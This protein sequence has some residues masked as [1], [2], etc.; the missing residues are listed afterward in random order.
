MAGVF[1]PRPDSLDWYAIHLPSGENSAMPLVALVWTTGNGFPSPMIGNAQMSFRVFW[2]ALLYS[3]NRPSREK[4]DATMSVPS[5][6]AALRFPR[7]PPTSRRDRC[8][9]FRFELNTMRAH[10]ATRSDCCRSPRRM[11]PGSETSPQV[12]Q[13]HVRIPARPCAT[14]P[15]ADRQETSGVCPPRVHGSPASRS[16]AGPVEPSKCRC[17]F[18]TPTPFRL[19]ETRWGPETDTDTG[20]P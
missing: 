2:L 10:P 12:E 9:P 19:G 11:S 15:R 4:S 6:A 18:P 16:L 8:T 5:S 14:S 20:P 3:R 1:L 7:R 13:P 17:A